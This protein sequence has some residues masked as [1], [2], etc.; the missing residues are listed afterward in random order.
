[1]IK[2]SPILVLWLL[3]ELNFG[4]LGAHINGL[5]GYAAVIGWL[6]VVCWWVK[7]WIDT[8]PAPAFAPTISAP[9]ASPVPPAPSPVQPP[10]TVPYAAPP[11]PPP[12][13]PVASPARADAVSADGVPRA[14]REAMDKLNAMTGLGSVKTEIGKL[15]DLVQLQRERERMRIKTPK[16]ALHMLFTGGPGTGKTTVAREL[17]AI[18]K[19]YGL[20][21]KGH[22]IECA[23]QDLVASYVGQ[24]AKKVEQMVDKAMGGILF[25]DEAYTLTKGS[26]GGS[27]DFGLEASD[28]LLKLAEDRRTEFMIILAGYSRDMYEFVDSNPGWKSRISRT[29]EFPDYEVPELVSIFN[30][31]LRGQGCVLAPNAEDQVETAC[32]RLKARGGKNFGNGRDVRVLVER[33]QEALATRIAGMPRR[34]SADFI[35]IT[36]ADVEAAANIV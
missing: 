18:Y 26:T 31:M 35:T 21:A 6:G 28:A 11:A 13:A 36:A 20:L 17:G 25:V 4:W 29:I 9:V 1:M 23:R 10:A 15:I 30:G 24:T 2:L 12:A 32:E 34:S 14:A 7:E 27:A 33:T 3:Y 19:A 16:P 22:V 5:F 8:R